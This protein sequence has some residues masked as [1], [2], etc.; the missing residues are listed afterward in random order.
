MVGV[1]SPNAS[2]VRVTWSTISEV[3][4]FTM[5]VILGLT[6]DT[7]T[8]VVTKARAPQHEQLA[9][10]HKCNTSKKQLDVI[11]INSTRQHGRLPDICCGIHLGL[12][13]PDGREH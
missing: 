3:L 12:P 5:Y 7:K 9:Q 1:G 2:Q 13:Y 11:A 8:N 6:V 10:Q 4:W